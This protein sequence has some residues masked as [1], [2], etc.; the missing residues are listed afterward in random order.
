MIGAILDFL[1]DP[2]HWRG[3][4][5][6]AR[7]LLLHTYYCLISVGLAALIA[8]PLGLYIGHT[9]RGSVIVV[10]ACNAMRGLPTLGLVTML[11]LI[12]GL[13]EGPAIAALVIL[14]VPAVLSG[15]YA[16]VRS[17]PGET[18]DAAKGMGMTPFQR[19]WRVEVPNATPLLM[20][21][22]RSAMLQ[23]VA[24]A[25]VAAY[26]N[27]GGLGTVLLIGVKTNEYERT[28]A[29]A[30]LIALL[31]VAL[32]LML[33]ALTKWLVPRGLALAAE[34]ARVGPGTNRRVR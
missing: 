23:V 16:G 19:L 32:D 29:A 24:T 27:L 33:A 28:A 18:V 4:D 1:T 5:G 14:A 34:N 11:V 13:G 25:A 2:A 8:V 10:G 6:L 30:I 31:A 3:P 21:G 20:G 9:G 17:V 15:T 7:Q 12:F 26:V 22:I